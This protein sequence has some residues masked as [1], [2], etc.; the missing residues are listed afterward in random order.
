MTTITLR[1]PVPKVVD[2]RGERYKYFGKFH[3]KSQAEAAKK[4]RKVVVAPIFE[5]GRTRYLAFWRKK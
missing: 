2:Y 5:N 1:Y 4:N 3:L